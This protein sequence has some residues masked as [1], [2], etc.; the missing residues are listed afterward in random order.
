MSGR[1]LCD[2]L[3]PRSEESC[4]LW[5]VVV[6]DLIKLK[7]EKSRALVRLQRPPKK[8]LEPCFNSLIGSS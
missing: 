4:R 8:R 3:I 1:C 5:C 2:E 6:C 7:P